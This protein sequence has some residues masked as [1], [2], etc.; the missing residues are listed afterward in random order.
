MDLSKLTLLVD[1]ANGASYKVAPR[2]FEQL[3]ARVIA[4]NVNPDGLNINDHAGSEYVRSDPSRFSELIQANAADAG[5]AFDGDADRVILFDDKGRLT[6]GDHML[7]ILADD[8]HAQ[9]RLLGNALVTTTMA[10]GA[11]AVYAK[12]RGFRVN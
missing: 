2:V 12:R 11:L 9:G 10:N 3:G 6:D 8:Y 7:A 1:C 5:I 4:L